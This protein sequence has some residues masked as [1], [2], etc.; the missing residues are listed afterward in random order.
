M[1]IRSN[2]SPCSTA[3][4]AAETYPVKREIPSPFLGGSTYKEP[5]THH[6]RPFSYEDTAYMTITYTSLL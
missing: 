6:P 3:T 4:L 1:N 2:T 5:D